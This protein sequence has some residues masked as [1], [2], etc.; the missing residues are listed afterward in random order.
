MRQNRKVQ[1]PPLRFS[2]HHLT[3]TTHL[4][5]K[6]S[7]LATL[8]RLLDLTSGSIQLDNVDLS[9]IPRHTIRSSLIA[10][11]QDPFI[12]PGTIR[13]NASPISPPPDHAIISA[14]EIVGLWDTIARRGGLS[15]NAEDVR[16]S[17]GQQQLFCLARAML[18]KSTVLVLDEATSSV[19]MQTD[20]LMQK[21]IREEFDKHTIVTVAHRLGT[22]IDSDRIAVMEKGRLVEFDTPEE[23]LK[24]ESVFRELYQS[25]R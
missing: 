20:S 11:P 17:H 23:L 8:F 15:A 24:R 6:S 12:L 10:I 16:L 21:I 3:T 22:I 14:L 4:S 9:L 7:L 1:T 5:G 2:P 25:E 18:R 13:F 19:D